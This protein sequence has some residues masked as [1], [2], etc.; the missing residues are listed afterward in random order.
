MS[1]SAW[2]DMRRVHEDEFFL[3]EENKSKQV[4]HDTLEALEERHKETD[5]K[6]KSFTK[7]VNP[8]TGAPFF[9]AQIAGH[10]VLDCPADDMLLMSQA[11]LLSL[12]ESLQNGDKKDIGAWKAF[13]QNQSNSE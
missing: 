12:I 3:K 4:L 7:G 13:L 9:K 11:T 5:E 6:L 1:T 8:I 2:D 10:Y